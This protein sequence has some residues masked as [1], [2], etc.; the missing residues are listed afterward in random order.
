MILLRKYISL[1]GVMC[2][3]IKGVNYVGN[4]IIILA[5]KSTYFKFIIREIKNCLKT[6]I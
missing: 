1:T 3:I 6:I 2:L 4:K 5:N